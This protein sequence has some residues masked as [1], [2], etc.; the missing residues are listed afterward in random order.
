VQHRVARSIAPRA[1]SPLAYNIFPF[2][3]RPEGGCEYP[4]RILGPV[5][6]ADNLPSQKVTDAMTNAR[7]VTVARMKT[8]KVLLQ[9][10]E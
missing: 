3:N 2:A 5:P 8:L 6:F 4:S 7:A 9:L 10:D 1:A